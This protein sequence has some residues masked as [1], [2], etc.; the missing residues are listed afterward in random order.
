M[1]RL[2]G[3][4]IAV[5][6]SFVGCV[7]WAQNVS[8]ERLANWPQFRG[9][10]ATGVAPMGNPPTEWSESKNIKWKVPIPGRG[11]SSPIVWGDRIFVLTAIKTDRTKEAA[12]TTTATQRPTV[13][14]V[15]YPAVDLLAQRDDNRGG[16]QRGEGPGQGRGRGGFG[17]RGGG[18]GGFG[19]AAPTNYHQF[20][21]MCLD[22]NT[23]ETIWQKTAAE[24]VPHEGHHQ[25]GTFAS[26]SPITDGKNLYA[27]FGSRGIHCYDL[28]GNPVWDVDLGDMRTRNS[29]GEGSSPAIADNTLV[30][31]WDHE[32]DSFIV[33]LDAQTGKEKWRK[34]RDEVSTWASPLIV[35]AA[36]RK[37]VITS[38]SNRV[39]SYDLANGDLLWECGGLGTNPIAM[40]VVIDNIA[41]CMSGHQEPAAVAVPLDAQG[42]VT[43]SEKVAWQLD[44]GSTPYIA[45]P[46]LYDG[47]LY[48]TKNRNAILSCF[49][50][51]TGKS[52]GGP[53]RL[54]GLETLYASPVAAAGR[55]YFPSLEGN[56]VVVKH[57]PELEIIA[58][59]RLDEQIID[60]TPAIVGNELILRGESHLYCI[61][62]N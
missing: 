20:V 53:K 5:F 1:R 14:Q 30:V 6:I 40:P 9:P 51:K 52:L 43:G 2:I 50:A 37:Q 12:E 3:S 32:A 42:D 18:R 25:T 35:E 62:E 56:T 46:V 31:M 22:R 38:G 19:I 57:G 60:A 26:G 36:G 10:L 7:V 11:S 13:R 39:R 45:S 23:G 28:D 41:I 47:L 15:S 24:V 33:A 58:T 59:N 55:I 44:D 4:G 54:Q 48:M 27:T 49:D 21:V 61:A 8:N 29:F 17:G 16:G 34:P